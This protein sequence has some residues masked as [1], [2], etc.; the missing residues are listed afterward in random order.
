[1][2]PGH[3]SPQP[4][5]TTLGQQ[6]CLTPPH[7]RVRGRHMSRENDILQGINSESGPLDIQSRPP[8]LVQ[9]SHVYRPDPWNG[10]RTPPYGV[11]AAHSRVPK[12][13]DR[14]QPGLNQGL[15]GGP[16]P[17]RVRTYPHTLLL[18][19][20]AETRCCHVAYCAWHRPT[21]GTWHNAS[22]L[23]APSHSSRIRRMPVHS[24]DRRRAQSTIRGPR[25]YSHV[26]IS[27]A[28][29]H[30]YSYGLL[31][32]NAAWTAIIMTL[33]DYSCVTLSALVIHIMYFF[34]YAPGPACRG[35]TSVYVPPLNYKREDTQPYKGHTQS[36]CQYNLHTVE[37][38]Y[39]APAA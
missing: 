23:R 18:P 4:R 35:S 22:G 1:V 36:H 9:D 13:Q 8:S 30:H 32:I 29:T 28:M 34:R 33:A 24:T 12:F 11:R 7:R 20:Q 3:D 26:T 21:G 14:T 27:R 6:Q 38:G 25:N 5:P 39:Y 17:T 2:G 15:G 19:A 16:V 31:P 10:I 37:V